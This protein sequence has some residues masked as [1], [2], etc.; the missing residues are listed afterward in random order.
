MTRLNEHGQPVGEPVPGWS[1]REDIGP[2]ELQGR[3][4]Q[5]VPLST[6][7]VDALYDV[8]V[9]EAS[10]SLWTYNPAGPFTNREGFSAYVDAALTAPATQAMTVCDAD[11]TPLG[12]A[13]FMRV[14]P[15]H[16]SAEVGAIVYSPRLQRT[17]AA[18]EAMY[19]M[20]R[21]VFVDLGYRR[22]EWKCDSLNEPSRRA[23]ARLG[24][25]YEGRFRNALVYKGRNRDTDWFSITDEE[26]P[27]VGAAL[28]AWLDPGNVTADS[29]RRS[30]ASFRT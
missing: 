17:T 8:L 3:W 10:D 13:S 30:L 5:V 25:R 19:L 18:T 28:E 11:G 23:A 7:H 6:T 9:A 2:V 24:F 14:E 20:A 1:R 27:V 26:W 22:Y 16:G 4:S 15:G 12:V 29:Q 21:H